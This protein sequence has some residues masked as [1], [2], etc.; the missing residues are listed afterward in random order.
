[1]LT[2]IVLLYNGYLAEARVGSALFS[3]GGFNNSEWLDIPFTKWYEQG[4]SGRKGFVYFRL[5][6]N[7]V[8]TM[9][10]DGFT[11]LEVRKSI[12]YPG[13]RKSSDGYS[14]LVK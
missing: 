10:H 14:P 11:C 9:F 12:G 1:M 13:I 2:L 7:V 3:N 8:L 4:N 5:Q 6:T